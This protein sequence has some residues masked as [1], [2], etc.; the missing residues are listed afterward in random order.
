MSEKLDQNLTD[1]VV[2]AAK[3]GLGLVPF[4]GSLLAEL[5]G[6]IIPRQRLD[7]LVDFAREL[8]H[9]TEGIDQELFRTK[10]GDENF[11]DLLE[12]SARQAAQAVT[13]ERRQYLAAMVTRGFEAS[14][15]SFVESRHLLRLLGQINDI[16][17]IWLRYHAYPFMSGDDDFRMT[18]AAVLEPIR[19]HMGSDQDTLDRHALQENYTEHLVS[20]GLLIRPLVVDSKTGQPHFDKATKTWKTGPA[21]TTP[22]G[23]LLLKHIGL[24]PVS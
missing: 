4:A 9:K 11:T 20:L 1:Y 16:E 22:L 21:Q 10:L 19:T 7:R 14:H 8:E 23:R 13:A 24:L 5:A 18:H 17:I 3:A 2:T 15:I 6:T 12:E